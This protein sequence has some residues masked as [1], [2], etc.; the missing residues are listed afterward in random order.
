MVEVDVLDIDPTLEVPEVQEALRNCLRE[1]TASELMVTMTK[2]PFRGTSK[3]FIK[4]E[5]SR[6]LKLLKVT[7]IK[8]GWVSCRARRKTAAS[9]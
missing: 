7:H 4:L 8:I 3:S 5:E 1:E 6:A 2:R 9:K